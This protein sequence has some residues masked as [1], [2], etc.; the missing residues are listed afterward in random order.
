MRPLPITIAP[1]Q[2]KPI[3]FMISSA[4]VEATS[5]NL[6]FQYSS[7]QNGPLSS[8][9]ST[10]PL[11]RRESI[12]EPHKVTHLHPSSIISYAMLRPPSSSADCTGGRGSD[13]SILVNLHGAGVEAENP[14]LANSFDSLPDLC[15]WLLFPSGA[16]TWSDDWR[17]WLLV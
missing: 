17:M 14:A 15:A 2:T 6:I 1:G 5:L 4:D 12:Y 10:L 11:R 7:D 16:T 8:I 13:V 3:A 9:T